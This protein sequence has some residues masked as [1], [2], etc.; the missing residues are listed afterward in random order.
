MTV[1]IAMRKVSWVAIPHIPAIITEHA[2]DQH[3]HGQLFQAPIQARHAE[4][5]MGA[6][7]VKFMSATEEG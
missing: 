3:L 2:S 4:A 1:A 6:A 5:C 7:D